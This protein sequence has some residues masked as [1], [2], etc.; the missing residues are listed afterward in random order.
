[1]SSRGEVRGSTR[2]YLGLARRC[3]I[4]FLAI[5]LT[6][7]AVA[8]GGGDSE[9]ETSNGASESSSA[10]AKELP[11]LSVSMA[12][13]TIAYPD[14]FVA[15]E[16]GMFKD[17]GV[18]VSIEINGSTYVT[19]TLGGHSDVFVSGAATVLQLA[20]QGVDAKLL[21]EAT[22]GIPSALAVRSD[23]PYKTVED[24]AGKKL[25]TSSTGAGHGSAV[26]LSRYVES[27]GLAPIKVVAA[28]A[29]SGNYGALVVSGGADAAIQTPDAMM[30][31]IVNGKLR[32]ILSGTEAPLSEILPMSIVGAGVIA[33]V[34]NLKDKDDALTK[35]IAGMRVADMWIQSRPESEVLEVLRKQPAFK[36]SSDDVFARNA[37]FSAPYWPESIGH[38]TPEAWEE[39]LP[40]FETW[41]TGLSTESPKA[42]FD[43][44]VDMSYWDAA[45][46][47]VDQIVA[48]KYPDLE[49]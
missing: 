1:M 20:G 15:Q 35:F 7:S 17:A 27:R 21:Y 39:S 28:T 11:S 14:F 43:E 9:S 37:E 48:E 42:S 3:V 18:D 49:S 13:T 5:G 38:V 34:R 25:V 19:D 40:V 33:P 8:C 46:P 41:G 6:L 4:T 30:A 32:V 2:R 29:P 24:L 10:E 23:S 47:I 44:R 45:T 26:A 16:L 12:L 22:G 36:E 31:D